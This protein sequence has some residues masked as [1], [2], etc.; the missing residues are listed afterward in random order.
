MRSFKVC[1]LLITV[2][3]ISIGQAS[4]AELEP[5]CV[6]NSPERRGQ[7]GCSLVEDKLLPTD[8]KGPL[9]WH[10]DQFESQEGAQAGVGPTSIALE[11]HG[12]WW[13]LS[14]ESATI[15]NHHNGSH[16]AQVAL[17]ALPPAKKYS[18]LV[19]SAYIPQGMTSRVH[20]HS[21]VETF[22][23]V[24]GEQCLE[25]PTHAYKLPK[26]GIL[27][28]PEGVTMRLVANGSVPR[29]ALAA[30]VYDASQP[31]TTRMDMEIAKQ[32][33]SCEQANP[34]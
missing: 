24:D 19:I 20:H 28:I 9:I 22:Y 5:P 11:A 2:D 23:T 18:Y 29:R 14:I 15:D 4:G 6:A 1:C 17:P 33:V 31:P 27:A 3:L 8:L 21:G 13:L 12:R 16:V 25:T 10:I 34:K 26:G 30:I 7:V 32:L